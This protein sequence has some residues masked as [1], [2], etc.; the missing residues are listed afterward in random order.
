MIYEIYM[1]ID[2]NKV[3]KVV[4][5]VCKQCGKHIAHEANFIE[6]R[7]ECGN[8]IPITAFH[9]VKGQEKWMT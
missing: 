3:Y 5:T 7:C 1:G 9:E 2:E 8:W 6:H 4:E